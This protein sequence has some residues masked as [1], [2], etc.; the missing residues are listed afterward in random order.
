MA[1]PVVAVKGE[2]LVLRSQP[3]S[4]FQTWGSSSRSWKPCH[5]VAGS[6]PSR[7]PLGSTPGARRGTAE[8]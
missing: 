7:T 2:E 3:V 5:S 8:L 4:G 6:L 1:S